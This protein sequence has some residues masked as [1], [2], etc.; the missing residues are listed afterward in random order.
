MADSIA[1]RLPESPGRGEHEHE[2][3]LPEVTTSQGTQLQGVEHGHEA[4]DVNLRALIGWLIVLVGMNAGVHFLMIG[5]FNGLMAYETRRD[6]LLSPLFAERQAPPLP[7]LLPNID[8]DR[9]HPTEA[10]RGPGDIGVAERADE[11]RALQNEG[12]ED[13]K[14]GEPTIP[15]NALQTIAKENPSAGTSTDGMKEEMPSAASGGRT[16]EDTLR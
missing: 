14:T 11:N 1:P 6:V 4:R 3:Y 7:R 5:M 13:P 10:Q 9:T 8:E 16:M 2:N 12:L 15:D